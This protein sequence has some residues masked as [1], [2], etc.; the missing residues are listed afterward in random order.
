MA[1]VVLVAAFVL[2]LGLALWSHRV[3]LRERPPSYFAFMQRSQWVGLVSA[4]LWLPPALRVLLPAVHAGL[5]ENAPWLR[6]GVAMGVLAG[7]LLVSLAT[8]ATLGFDVA[9]RA[10]LTDWTW[11][12][13]RRDALL[14]LAGTLLPLTIGAAAIG[15]LATGG[16]GGGALA[17]AVAVALA[18]TLLGRRQRNAGLTFHAVTSGEL[19][20]RVFAIAARA[21][22]KL[23]QLYVVPLRRVRLANAFAVTNNVVLLTDVLLDHLDRDEVDAVLAHE[24]AHLARK[25]P[26]KLARG[27]FLLTLAVAASFWGG[28]WVLVFAPAAGLLGYLAFARRIE[29]ATDA[30]AIDLGA[31]PEALVTGLARLSRLSQ[32]PLRWSRARECLLTHPSLERR[33]MRLA[34][35]AGLDPALLIDLMDHTP[36][37]G[38]RWAMPEAVVAPRAFGSDFRRRAQNQVAWSLLAVSVFVPAATIWI[39]K[40]LLLSRLA[41]LAL[42]ILVTFLAWQLTWLLLAPRSLLALRRALEARRWPEVREAGRGRESFVGLAPHAA[43]RLYEGFAEWDAGFL[44]ITPLRIDYAGEESRFSLTPAEVREVWLDRGLPGWIRV[45][46]VR[47]RWERADG[48]SGVF[49]LIPLGAGNAIAAQTAARRLRAS[50]STWRESTVKAATPDVMANLGPPPTM[51]VTS[52]SPRAILHAP[53]LTLTWIVQILMSVGVGFVCGLSTWPTVP[54][55]WDVMLAAVATHCLAIAPIAFYREPASPPALPV[56]ARK[57]A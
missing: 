6:W 23:T 21:G 13:A 8:L 31:R 35:R 25:D 14:L 43:P 40:F 44:A 49:G 55:I 24:M 32:V 34:A 52:T 30:R 7:P 20:D 51:D 11:S 38:E 37:A 15:A 28:L 33:A 17:V 10:G 57:A 26:D 18:I 4:L 46:A 50:L 12:E 22:V 39:L 3:A 45:R 56:A 53:A 27:L 5:S 1:G 29:F 2:P 54:G 47:L 36:A 19:R 9:R 16:R 42:A 41:G 48:S